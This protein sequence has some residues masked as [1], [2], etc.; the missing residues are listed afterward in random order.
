MTRKHTKPSEET[1]ALAALFAL[2][3][4]DGDEKARFE[5]H[6]RDAGTHVGIIGSRNRIGY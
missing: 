3:S 5:H 6:L 1:R 2:G 4:L